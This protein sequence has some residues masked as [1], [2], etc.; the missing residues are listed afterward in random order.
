METKRLGKTDIEVTPVGMGVLTIGRTQLNLPLDEGADVV[1]YAL[2]QGINFLDT[3]E[4]Y[5]T[6]PYMKRALDDLAPAFS[7]S[8]LSRPVISS[9]S[10]VR[11]Y[12]GMQRAIDD[13]RLALDIDQIDIFLL[14]EVA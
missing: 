3:A 10:L 5:Q 1:R 8:A 2:E 11:D 12:D 7:Q 13:C 6:Y 9:K 14:H 4:Y